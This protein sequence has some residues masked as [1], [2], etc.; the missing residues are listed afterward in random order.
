MATTTDMADTINPSLSVK[1]PATP[2][3]SVK[4]PATPSPSV[5]SP[6]THQRGIP[7]ARQVIAV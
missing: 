1:S 6:A 2:S 4:S 3:P 7:A 5:K